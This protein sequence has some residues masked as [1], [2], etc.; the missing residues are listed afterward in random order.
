MRGAKW[1]VRHKMAMLAWDIFNKNEPSIVVAT[2]LEP[3]PNLMRQNTGW[4]LG[5]GDCK[6]S[7]PNVP[8]STNSSRNRPAP[9]I[10]AN[11]LALFNEGVGHAGP[12]GIDLRQRNI[13]V[14]STNGA[15]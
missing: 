1:L 3:G 10:T 15:R 11:E 5:R 8:R 12:S 4:A 9:T 7:R 14:V 2:T 13:G 6:T